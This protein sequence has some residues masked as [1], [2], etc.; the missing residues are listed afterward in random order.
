MA[1][2]KE[3]DIDRLRDSADIVEIVSGYTQLKKSG[4]ARFVGLCPFH[5]E[6][7]PS[8]QVDAGKGLVH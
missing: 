4:G 2:I 5:S 7:T 8:F 1:R 6:K 3:D